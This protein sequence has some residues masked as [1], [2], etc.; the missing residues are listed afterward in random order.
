M[1]NKLIGKECKFVTHVPTRNPEVPDVH[2]IK[3]LLWYEDGSRKPNLRIVRN[4][5][6][7]FWITSPSKQNHQESKEWEHVDN[8]MRYESTESDLRVSVARA[9]GKMWS[10]D[11]LRKLSESPYV[12]GTD[13]SSSVLIK[14]EYQERF[15]DCFSAFR[16]AGYDTETD[17][18]HGTKRIIMASAVFEKEVVV[19]VDRAVAQGYA[20]FRDLLVAKS[21]QMLLDL[22]DEGYT[23]EFVMCDSS[24]DIVKCVFAKFHAWQP[25]FL[26]IWNVNFDVPVTLKCIADA[27]ADPLEILCDP[28][29]PY[30]FRRCEYQEDVGKKTTAS[31]KVKPLPG[32]MKWHV[33]HLTASFYVIDGMSAFKHIRL[34]EQE[35]SSYSLDAI[36]NLH[37]ERGKLKH[38][39]EGVDDGTLEWHIQMQANYPAEYAMY[40]GYDS[41]G[42][43]KLDAKTKDLC[44]T[45]PS[46]SGASVFPDFKSQPRRIR[47][48]FFFYLLEQGYVL[49]TPGPVIEKPVEEE[50]VAGDDDEDDDDDEECNDVNAHDHLG[51]AGWI[52]TLPAFSQV[53]GMNVVMEDP[54]MFS[55]FRAFT[56]DSDAVSAYP[57]ATDALNVSRDTTRY[58]ISDIQGIDGRTFRLQ[59]MNLLYGRVNAVEYCCEMLN[60]PNL[61]EMLDDFMLDLEAGEVA[62]AS[63]PELMAA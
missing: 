5:K 6:R 23:F 54:N 51:L 37:L 40:N 56:Y 48:A 60:A 7:P 52:S 36:M 15:P 19:A 21:K 18:V 47:D 27:K 50:Q 29:I 10:R 12:Y 22:Y 13:V 44:Y 45:L 11:S 46:F 38:Q 42:M 61:D 35:Q 33:L 28:A 58:E 31:G 1:T 41:V 9:L 30:Q 26:E 34:A 39:I 32:H 53:P 49:G 63:K 55:G 57:S 43:L 25:D 62:G 14:R 4:Y 8:L 2:I 16:V 20:N 59:N 17:V 3:E 24:L